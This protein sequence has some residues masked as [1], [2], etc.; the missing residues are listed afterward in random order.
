MATYRGIQVSDRVQDVIRYMDCID[1][2]REALMA[3][4]QR[5]DLLDVLGR[6]IDVPTE[7]SRT[8]REFSALN[9]AL[10]DA[11]AEESLKKVTASLGTRAQMVVDI[12]VRN[13]FERTADIGFLATDED[14]RQFLSP[15][16]MPSTEAI[17]QRLIEYRAKYSVYRNVV[18]LD[19]GGEIRAAAETAGLPDRCDDAFIRQA[20][21]TAAPYVETFAPSDLAPGTTPQLIYSHRIDDASGRPLGV[22]ALL[23]G[24]AEELAGVFGTLLAPDDWTIAALLDADGLVLASSDPAQLPI[25][26]R[27]TVN[28]QADQQIVR[29]A[30]RRYIAAARTTA[31]YQ[32]YAGPGWR[33]CALI[34]VEV[35]FDGDS[36]DETHGAIACDSEIFSAAVR[37]IPRRAEAIQAALNLTV[38]NGT[39]AIG[40]DAQDVVARDSDAAARRTLLTE[41]SATGGRTRQVFA[42]AIATLTSTAVGAIVADCAAS[43]ALA[44]DI[45]DRN[46]YE[47]ANDCRWWALTTRFREALA[48]PDTIAIFR[49]ELTAIL[50]YINDLYTVYTNLILFDHDGL[51][52]AVSD[53]AQ[54]HLVGT[55]L[56]DGLA[57]RFMARAATA[58]YGV[59]DFRPTP[60]Y[61][62][63]ATYIYGAPV[64]HPAE[65]GR[66]IGG[67]AIVF[68]G[69]LQFQSMLSDS[70]P[71]D[72][73]GEVL[74]GAALVFVDGAGR[75]LSSTSDDHP[76]GSKLTLPITAGDPA[77][78][79]L[80]EWQGN[81]YAVGA[82]ASTGYREYKGP[83]DAYRN[84]VHAI[85]VV[86]LGAQQPVAATARQATPLAAIPAGRSSRDGRRVATFQLGH[87]RLA[88]PCERLKEAMIPDRIARASDR[89]HGIAGYAVHD[90]RGVLVLDPRSYF[91]LPPAV[92]PRRPVIMMRTD[93][94]LQGLAVDALGEV[95][96]VPA[97]RL[98]DPGVGDTGSGVEAIIQGVGDPIVLLD[99]DAFLAALNKARPLAA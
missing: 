47:R 86:P 20:L 88:L 31:G 54:E 83:A 8:R 24:F 23:F 26:T 46:L 11:L 15:G 38:W 79:R 67:I 57:T 63:G 64:L 17:R 41:I 34:P 40:D 80:M 53:P 87:H 29:L 65:P 85:C 68:D 84:A 55:T 32:G 51:V 58:F 60:L 16:A 92:E 62:D 99:A 19:T 94:G 77:G 93:Q 28:P 75:I 73:A 61:G 9:A 48:A 3:L 96:T 10:I 81:S 91:G 30:G 7:V 59:S 82:S 66:A 37:D 52:Q 74:P 72:A 12:V 6:V 5:W 36:G 22:L 70:L 18:L 95:M 4:E 1:E 43:A 2:S 45:M 25:A 56:P 39:L 44:V 21:A 27:L 98:S 50:R 89:S 33:G 35:A 97:D 13:L 69:T 42:D 71:T 90:G 14:L 78:T 49:A 76:P